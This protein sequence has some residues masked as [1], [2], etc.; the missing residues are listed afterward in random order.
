[1]YHVNFPRYNLY[2]AY[3]RSKIDKN[4][5]ATAVN[6]VMACLILM[7]LILLFFNIVRA[8]DKVTYTYVFK[9][10]FT[11]RTLHCCYFVLSFIAMFAFFSRL[12]ILSCSFIQDLFLRRFS[13]SHTLYGKYGSK[14]LSPSLDSPLS[15]SPPLLPLPV[16][17]KYH[18]LGV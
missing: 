7:Q 6:C 11:L 8:S 14:S 15:L 16:S 9:F 1:M 13:I 12:F 4:M 10:F 5:H 18:G 2:F 17:L 3:K